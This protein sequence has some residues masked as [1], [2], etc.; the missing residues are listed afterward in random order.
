VDAP[1]PYELE[2]SGQGPR[3][4]SGA[5]QS[6]KRWKIFAGLKIHND[7]AIRIYNRTCRSSTTATRTAALELIRKYPFFQVQPGN[8]LAGGQLHAFARHR[9]PPGIDERGRGQ[10]HGHQR[11]VLEPD[12]RHV[13]GREMYRSLYYTKSLA[14]ASACP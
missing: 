6:E 9:A 13:H 14:S 12:E 7:I 11:H 5:I 3:K 4:H 10:S 2:L 8:K 1:A